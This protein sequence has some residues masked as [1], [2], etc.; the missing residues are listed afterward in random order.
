[1]NRSSDLDLRL[2]TA[3]DDVIADRVFD[4][5]TL[6][7]AVQSLVQGNPGSDDGISPNG[8]EQDGKRGLADAQ[9]TRGAES[10]TS[11]RALALPDS[12]DSEDS[13][14]ESSK[15]NSDPRPLNSVADANREDI[16]SSEQI[17]LPAYR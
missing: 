2:A 16:D 17:D 5:P 8:R 13:L 1:M 15:N 3:L 7:T 4:E 12:D 11:S 14:D 6:E 9:A 10:M